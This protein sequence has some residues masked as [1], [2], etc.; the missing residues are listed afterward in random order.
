MQRMLGM[1]ELKPQDLQGLSPETLTALAAHLLEHIQRQADEL[2]SKGRE[3]EIGRAH[4]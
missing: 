1:R 3:L 4:V 2:Q